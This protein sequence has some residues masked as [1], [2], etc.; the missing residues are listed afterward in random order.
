MS[1]SL[2]LIEL[3]IFFVAILISSGGYTIRLK[4][5]T[6]FHSTFMTRFIIG[7]MLGLEGR[8][9]ALFAC[10]LTGANLETA[11]IRAVL[12]IG[13]TVIITQISHVIT[14]LDALLEKEKVEVPSSKSI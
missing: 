12:F 10:W 13:L 9:T 5:H 14:R 1:F 11:T 4:L 8:V 7:M 2:F 6:H 3:V